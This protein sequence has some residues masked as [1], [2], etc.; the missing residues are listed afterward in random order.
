MVVDKRTW[1]PT[2]GDGLD[3]DTFLHVSVG[4]V[5]AILALE[6]L[7]SAES[8]DKG[9]AACAAQFTIS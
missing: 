4:R 5:I 6:N 7:L 8:V 9:R 2:D 3:A 1:Q